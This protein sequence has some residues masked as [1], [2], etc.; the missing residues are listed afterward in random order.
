MRSEDR[1]LARRQ[2]DKRLSPLRNTQSLA[3]PARGWIKAIREALGMTSKQLGMRVGVS[4]P[5][6]TKIEQAEKGGSVTLETL[7]RTAQAMDCQLVYAFVPRAPLQELV[8]ERARSRA[9]SILEATSH[10]MALEDQRADADT[11]RAHLEQLTRELMEKSGPE[12]WEE[13]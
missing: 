13:E 5:R 11:D 4:Q 12:L 6:I 1:A 2:L 10:S 9:K 8:E 3:R 7:R